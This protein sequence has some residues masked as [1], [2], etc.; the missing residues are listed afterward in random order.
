MS[1][2]I[3]FSASDLISASPEFYFHLEYINGTDLR[4]TVDDNGI[5][6]S[7]TVADNLFKP[8]MQDEASSSRRVNGTRLGLAITANLLQRMA[9]DIEIAINK[10]SG[11]TVTI[12]LPMR[13]VDGLRP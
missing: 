6:M 2:A 10:G 3:K 9:G 1:K 8:F 7:A 11:T 4:V 12:K 13:S 5:S